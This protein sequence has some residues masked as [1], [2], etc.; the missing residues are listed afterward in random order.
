MRGRV[1]ESDIVQERRGAR[2]TI[3]SRRRGVHV[4]NDGERLLLRPPLAYAVRP[5]ALRVL[6]GPVA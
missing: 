1:G 5:G 3:H 6:A 2:L 4:M